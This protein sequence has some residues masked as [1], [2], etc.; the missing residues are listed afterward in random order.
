MSRVRQNGFT[1][2]ET[3]MFLAISGLLILVISVGQDSLRNKQRFRDAVQRLHSRLL[4][5]QEEVVDGT[6]STSTGGVDQAHVIFMKVVVFTKDSGSV[7]IYECNIARSEDPQPSDINCVYTSS[8]YNM[9]WEMKFVK[10]VSDQ[11]MLII[12]RHPTTGQLKML[13]QESGG[14][15]VETNAR[16]A[17]DATRFSVPPAD[18]KIELIGPSGGGTARIVVNPG[19]NQNYSETVFDN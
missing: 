16:S 11:K 13:V 15:D 5:V 17:Y 14:A 9:E 12:Y 8:D 2:V 18:G 19:G 6:F 7:Q 4:R 10:D 1:I 3:L